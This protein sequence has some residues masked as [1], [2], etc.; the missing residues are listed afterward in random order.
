MSKL[1]QVVKILSILTLVSMIV[2]ACGPPETVTETVTEAEFNEEGFFYYDAK[3]DADFQPGKIVLAGSVEGKEAVIEITLGIADGEAFFDLLSATLGGQE[4][5]PDLFD[6]V[7][8]DL[9]TAFYTPDEGYAV[10]DVAITDD[11]LTIPA[12]L[13]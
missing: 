11:E 6:S 7:G 2:V 3:F 12:T 10:T 1:I 13:Q 4:L 8:A 5:P 9:S